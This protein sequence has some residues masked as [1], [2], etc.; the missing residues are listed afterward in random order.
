LISLTARLAQADRGRT[1]DMVS[2][3]VN[4][5]KHQQFLPSNAHICPE[6]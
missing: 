6:C 3:M 1:P 2:L 5:P 4:D